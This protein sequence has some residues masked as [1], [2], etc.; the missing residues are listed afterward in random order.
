MTKQA[1]RRPDW[2][3]AFMTGLRQGIT[4]MAAAQGAGISAATAYKL[5]KNNARFVQA[6][7]EAYAAGGRR[8]ASAG[9]TR[10]VQWRKAFLAALAETS[11]VSAAAA[12]LNI[13]TSTVYKLRREDPEFAAAWRAA[14]YEGYEHLEMEVLAFLRGNGGDCKLDVANAIRLLAAHRQT[15]VEI[16][17][18]EAEDDE[19]AVLESIDRFIDDMRERRAANTAILIEAGTG[20]AVE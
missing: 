18:M 19:Q 15:V 10:T 14:L 9:F 4:I 8:P 6:W 3:P 5:R 16:R 7:D 17:A 11:N 1:A 13:P 20:D 2:E 12:G